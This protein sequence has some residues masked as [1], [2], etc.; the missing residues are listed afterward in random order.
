MA[1]S[2]STR[3][4]VRKPTESK[5]LTSVQIMKEMM[6]AKCVLETTLHSLEGSQVWAAHLMRHGL[7]LLDSLYDR[8]DVEGVRS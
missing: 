7:K 6:L 5:R 1:M 3:A 8:I 4:A 2:K